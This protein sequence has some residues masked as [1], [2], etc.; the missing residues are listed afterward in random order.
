[1]NDIYVQLAKKLD[2]MP[3]GFPRTES[4]VE[5]RI[6]RKIFSPE[7]AE[8]ALKLRPLPE[9]AEAIAD[10]LSVPLPVMQS[11]LDR[12]VERGQI[13]SAKMYGNQV[14]IFMPFVIGIWEF[15]LSRMDKELA[16]LF[17]EYAP[18]LLSTLGTFSPALTRVVPVNAQI[19]GTHEVHR[20]EDVRQM[21]DKGRSFLLMEC[22][23]RKERGVQGHPC[24]HTLET[25]LGFSNHE[26]AFDRYP[27]GR[28]ISKA[29]AFK[30]VKLAESEGLVHTT[31]NVK[32]GH[33]FL[34]NCCSCCCGIIRGVKQFNAPYLMAKSNFVAWIDSDQCAQCGV[35]KDERCPMD[36]IVEQDGTL[37]VRPER[38]IGCGVCTTT[39]PTSAVT[40]VRK[41]ES[42][43][44]EPPANL[45]EWYGQRANSRGIKITI[46]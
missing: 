27:R 41:P 16:E 17:E 9:T 12:M 21:I 28:I 38:C 31:Y 43:R 36:A 42:E 2:E 7:E 6:L 30:V 24:S 23:C 4:S 39:C 22:I 44:D 45:L 25:C 32:S 33:S 18:T 14:Y 40:L 11:L 46:S 13:A 34:C 19:D 35:C 10:R 1:M 20:Y 5:L 29:E 3:H 15:Q 26:G 37:A 8:I